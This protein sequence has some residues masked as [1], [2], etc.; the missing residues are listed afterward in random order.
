MKTDSESEYCERSS[1][2]DM[3]PMD[4]CERVERGI[5]SVKSDYQL[6]LFYLESKCPFLPKRAISDLSSQASATFELSGSLGTQKC[7]C[8]NTVKLHAASANKGGY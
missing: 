6:F 3:L 8:I 5:E 4:S 2:S 7:A 1:Q